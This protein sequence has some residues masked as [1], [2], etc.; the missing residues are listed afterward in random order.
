MA[1]AKLPAVDLRSFKRFS[2]VQSHF[3]EFDSRER[4][5]EERYADQVTFGKFLRSGK[6]LVKSG[7]IAVFSS[8]GWDYP[9]LISDPANGIV[10]E[11]A[12][13]N[14]KRALSK[15]EKQYFGFVAVPY[16][17]KSQKYLL[18][19]N[20]DEGVDNETPDSVENCDSFTMSFECVRRLLDLKGVNEVAER[21]QK[22]LKVVDFDNDDYIEFTK[23]ET[24]VFQKWANAGRQGPLPL[25]PPKAGYTARYSDWH[26]SATVLLYDSEKK[27]S[28]LIGQDENTYFGVQLVDNPKTVE[29]AYVSLQHPAVRGKT[30]VA[31]QGEWFALSVTEDEVPSVAECVAEVTPGNDTDTIEQEYVCFNL[32]RAEGP[33]SARHQIQASEI[34]VSKNGVV[35]AKDATLT[36]ERGDHVDL[37]TDGWVA[38][39]RNTAVQ[40]VSV[41]GVD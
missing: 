41:E 20:G 28:F 17:K 16:K 38:Y 14:T 18:A 10:V 12:L 19:I 7:K 34:R 27:A 29:D 3:D 15:Y 13:N 1:T 5:G 36:H 32:N 11:R 22:T 21:L 9:W 8:D 37:N 6:S 30:N 35:Y 2:A 33:E 31:R 4:T 39:Y 26:R 23:K 25:E 24:N 40:A